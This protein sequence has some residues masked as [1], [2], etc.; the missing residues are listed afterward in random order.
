[1]TNDA[2]L[3]APLPPM[4]ADDL[5]PP[6]APA[7]VNDSLGS[8]RDRMKAQRAKVIAQRPNLWLDVPGY[9]GDL[10]AEYQVIDWDLIK[11]IGE[12]VEASNDERK[13][14]YGHAAI[15]GAATVA[16]YARTG[17]G[18][19]QYVESLNAYVVPMADVIGLGYPARYPEVATYYDAPAGSVQESVM[20]V[21]APVGSKRE[22][23]VTIHHNAIMSWMGKARAE[24]ENDFLGESNA[25][26]Q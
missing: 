17:N 9:N 19:G 25:A 13:E 22:L 21:I 2:T 8:I 14:L 6:A 10:V 15:I 4:P 12:R 26:R 11:G 7:P 5:V 23:Q 24:A 1:M 3:A 18:T 20:G 16:L